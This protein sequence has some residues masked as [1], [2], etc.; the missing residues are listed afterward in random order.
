MYTTQ[1]VNR[2]A[3][4][5]PFIAPAGK[6]VTWRIITV[7]VYGVIGFCVFLGV[8]SLIDDAEFREHFR[9]II[10]IMKG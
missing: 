3:W 9:D 1:V 10:R 7:V 2:N 5:I 8:K 4:L 6:S